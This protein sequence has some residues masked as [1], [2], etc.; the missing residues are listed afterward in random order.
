MFLDVLKHVEVAVLGHVGGA[1]HWY[2]HLW[3][4]PM[5]E[6][7]HHQEYRENYGYFPDL[8]DA[9]VFQVRFLHTYGDGLSVKTWSLGP[10]SL[11]KLLVFTWSA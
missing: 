3:K 7:L 9:G 2:I 10:R 4:R 6:I 5:E 11:V 8:C 1:K